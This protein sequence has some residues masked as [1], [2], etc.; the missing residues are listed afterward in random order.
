MI[1]EWLT[2]NAPGFVDLSAA[3]K[4]AVLD[5]SML[6][7]LFEAR[8]LNNHGSADTISAAAERWDRAG[9][10]EENP[11]VDGLRYFQTRYYQDGAQTRHYAYLRFGRRD[12]ENLVSA[13][14]SGGEHSNVEKVI[15]TLIVIYRF[16]NNLFHGEKWAYELRDQE[17]NF[18]VSNAILIQAMDLHARVD[19]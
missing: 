14:L 7:S 13:V 15:A 17:R 16:R 9:A 10:L 19:G 11:F 3:E 6:W 18:A 8:A 12:R 5:F 4:D 1:R 2:Q